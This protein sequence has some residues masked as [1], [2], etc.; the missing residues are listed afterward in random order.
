MCVDKVFRPNDAKD[1]PSKKLPI[2]TSKLEKGDAAFH[3]K[4]QF[5]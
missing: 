4:K 1:N 3:D 2:S 5:L